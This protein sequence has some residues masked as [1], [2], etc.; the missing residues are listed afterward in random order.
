MNNS[1]YTFNDLGY[2]GE[3]VSPDGQSMCFVQG[4][5]YDYLVNE[6]SKIDT[7]WESK[8][9]D[10]PFDSYESHLSAFLESYTN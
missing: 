3:I 10:V 8:N 2:G 4:D 7:L 9:P 5:D 1:I 6:I